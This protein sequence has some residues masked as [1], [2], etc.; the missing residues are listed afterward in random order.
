[1]L[2]YAGFYVLQI[3]LAFYTL[4]SFRW[5]VL[6][7]AAVSFPIYTRALINAVAGKEQKWHVTG[8]KKKADSPF[9]F[10]MPQVL[11]FVFL[12]LTSI[13]SLWRDYDNSSFTL[14][15]AWNVTNTFILGAFMVVALKESRRINHP[16][17]AAAGADVPATE[18]ARLTTV[19]VPPA[20]EST[21]GVRE[22][23]D[24]HDVSAAPLPN[25]S[26]PDSQSDSESAP[27]GAGRR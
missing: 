24:I 15:S 9:N 5:E 26:N 8:S 10:I 14:A 21:L 7:L 23:T 25:S 13:V 12:I 18:P 2:Y 3:A 27:V 16:V 17:V 1:L 6:T 20:L 4:G 19:I 11:V 22:I